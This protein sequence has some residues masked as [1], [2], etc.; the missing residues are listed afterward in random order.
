MATAVS[1]GFEWIN[2]PAGLSL[3]YWFRRNLDLLVLQEFHNGPSKNL[4]P[5]QV[6]L[7]TNEV[8]GGQYAL[9]QSKRSQGT[10]LCLGK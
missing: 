7:V 2:G 4:R 9:W 3:G 10:W 1:D 6:L 5:R 8:N